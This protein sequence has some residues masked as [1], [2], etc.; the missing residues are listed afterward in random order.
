MIS[1]TG[2]R[3]SPTFVAIGLLS[4]LI[5]NPAS[6][7]ARWVVP[8]HTI[9]SGDKA[10]AI[11][12]DYSLSNAVFHPD[13]ALG[14]ISLG[15]SEN[16]IS[17]DPLQSQ[18]AKTQ[19]VLT[20][21][22]GEQQILK[23]V[24]LGRKSSSY[25]TASN[26]GTYRVDVVQ[27][28]IDVTLFTAADGSEGRLFGTPD[29]VSQ[30]LP[31]GAQQVERLTYVNRVQAFVT[32]NQITDKTLHPSGNGLELKHFTHPNEVFSNESVRYQL[33]LS[34]KSLTPSSDKTRIK[35]T[36]GGTRYRNRRGNFTPP[37]NANGEFI[38]RWPNAGLYL[39]EIE[40]ELNG[41][42]GKKVYALFLTLEIQPE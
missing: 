40:H 31:E 6:G 24:D 8:S 30:K 4:C 14:G 18:L 5:A 37:I 16:A 36:P 42:E 39:I 13:I 20:Q 23:S 15:D 3:C 19:V 25:F 27:P 2:F 1:C 34:G 32:R 9:V 10:T 29:A 12:L 17:S 38:V 41:P 7:H 21:P 33:L 22:N 11:S 28:P 35:I 26:N